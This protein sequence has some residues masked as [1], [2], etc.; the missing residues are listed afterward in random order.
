VCAC[1]RVCVYACMRACTRVNVYAC[2]RACL[3]ACMCAC[4]RAHTLPFT[5]PLINQSHAFYAC[6]RHLSVILAK[7]QILIFSCPQTMLE[8]PSAPVL[9]GKPSCTSARVRWNNVGTR[10]MTGQ[11]V[12]ASNSS[13]TLCMYVTCTCRTHTHTHALFVMARRLRRGGGPRSSQ[14]A[15]SLSGRALTKML[16][17]G[18]TSRTSS[19]RT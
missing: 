13:S 1:V 7:N 3:R 18:W 12:R 14:T 6:T 2:V 5:H 15:C 8:T 10:G 17:E 9:V 16:T 4:I 11:Q 19:K